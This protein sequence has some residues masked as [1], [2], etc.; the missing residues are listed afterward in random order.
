MLDGLSPYM[1]YVRTDVII[2]GK[3]VGTEG[4]A[5]RIFTAGGGSAGEDKEKIRTREA[6]E[7]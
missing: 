7:N 3:T 1:G 2:A 5:V 4:D 6:V